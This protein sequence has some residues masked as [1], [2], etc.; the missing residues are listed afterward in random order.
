[1]KKNLDNIRGGMISS[2]SIGVMCLRLTYK[3]ECSMMCPSVDL[4]V[5]VQDIV[6]KKFQGVWPRK[7][8][9]NGQ[10]VCLNKCRTL[11]C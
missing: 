1:M 3:D 10:A 6:F 5:F 7:L 11:R 2:L 4:S 9:M 8:V